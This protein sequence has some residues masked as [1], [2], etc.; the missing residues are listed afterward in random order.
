VQR[1]T[2]RRFDERSFNTQTLQLRLF[3][4]LIIMQITLELKF[5]N[6]GYT[7]VEP[8]PMKASQ[9]YFTILQT[10]S[11]SSSSSKASTASSTT[12]NSRI[13]NFASQLLKSPLNLTKSKPVENRTN[14]S[15]SF[16]ADHEKTS[17]SFHHDDVSFNSE[18]NVIYFQESERTLNEIN[19]FTKKVNQQK[20]KSSTSKLKMQIVSDAANSMKK[21]IEKSKPGSSHPTSAPT[22]PVAVHPLLQSYDT[23]MKQMD[24]HENMMTKIQDIYASNKD[25]LLAQ[26]DHLRSRLV[27]CIKHNRT[28]HIQSKYRLDES[29]KLSD[30]LTKYAQHMKEMQI[31]YDE[32]IR[33]KSHEESSYVSWALR[34][35]QSQSSS[36]SSTTS[37]VDIYNKTETYHRYRKMIKV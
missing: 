37:T 13:T 3:V 8:K 14:Q 35:Q 17:K 28:L 30:A 7:R 21:M 32:L 25:S 15:R 2:A 18:E 5:L 10:M 9:S 1:V 20:N 31:F 11:S 12:T 34:M 29:K 6:L 24:R 23:L 16:S 4:D 36:S 26:S 19:E 33:L 22:S 27:S